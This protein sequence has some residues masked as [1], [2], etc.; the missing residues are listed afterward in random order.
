MFRIHSHRDRFDF[1][2][3][4][5]FNNY[6]MTYIHTYIHTTCSTSTVY[7]SFKYNMWSYEPI[8]KYL[9]SNSIVFVKEIK[10]FN[11]IYFLMLNG[12]SHALRAVN[13]VSRQFIHVLEYR[14]VKT[15]N[16]LKFIHCGI[17]SLFPRLFTATLHQQT[18]KFHNNVH[19]LTHSLTHSCTLKHIRTHTHTHTHTRTHTH[20]HTHTRIHSLTHTLTENV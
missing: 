6:S 15:D 14:S 10:M 11:F 13:A 7:C 2:Q 16:C 20:T 17:D 3:K 1:K 19:S 18:E 5:S 12:V 8:I 4:F 9:Y